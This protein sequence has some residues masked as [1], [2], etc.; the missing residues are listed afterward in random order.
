MKKNKKIYLMAIVAAGAAL[1]GCDQLRN[2]LGLDHYQA[3]PFRIPVNP[4]L[5]MPPDYN[6]RPPVPGAPNPGD[7]NHKEKAQEKML[8]QKV[9][10]E[11]TPSD[12]EKS[13]L[14]HTHQT[15]VADPNIRAEVDKEAEEEKTLFGKLKNIGSNAT[16]N[17]SKGSAGEDFRKEE[18]APKKYEQEQNA[19]K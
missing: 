18:A 9:S 17:L 4:P 3:D 19:G 10:L 14:S 15:T 12:A 6:L 8:G 2:T 16:T 7:V 13:I 5:S 11:K 1:S